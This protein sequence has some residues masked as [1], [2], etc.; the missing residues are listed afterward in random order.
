[1][2]EKRGKKGLVSI[3]VILFLIVLALIAGAMMMS[4][5]PWI[6]H[7]RIEISSP[8][9]E[10]DKSDL[11][12][13]FDIT[14]DESA[15]FISFK[16]SEDFRET[17]MQ[18]RIIL[19]DRSK[20]SSVLSNYSASDSVE[21]DSSLSELKKQ[22]SFYVS[23]SHSDNFRMHA[24]VY[25]DLMNTIL[26]FYSDRFISNQTYTLMREYIDRQ[27]VLGNYDKLDKA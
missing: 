19:K 25:T 22:Y 8:F 21:Y 7:T 16:Y 26:Y 1:M 20:L 15:E 3:L 13:C 2:E 6:Y 23:Y 14:V 5:Y 12:T 17:H 24:F 9:T 18:L 27:I 11:C 10:Q 4:V